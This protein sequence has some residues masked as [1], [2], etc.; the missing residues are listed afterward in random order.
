MV[1]LYEVAFEARG[2]LERPGV[3]TFVEKTSVVAI[4]FG[5]EDYNTG[6]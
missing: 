2:L 5:F 1:V 6:K 4:D 3:E